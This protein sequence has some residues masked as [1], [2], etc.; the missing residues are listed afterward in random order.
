[1]KKV[2]AFVGSARKKNTYNSVKEFL[3]RLES[4]GGVETEIVC[5]HDYR[6]D[7]C[8]GCKLCMDKGEELCPLKDDRDMLLEK[9]ACSDGVILASP[10][11]AFQVSGM[12]KN[13]LDRIGGFNLHRPRF[14]GKAFTNIVVQGI[15]GGDKIVKYLDFVGNGLGFTTAKGVCLTALEPMS[16]YERGKIEKAIRSFY[17]T[18]HQPT[19]P[20]P[21]ILKLMIFRLSRTSMKITLNEKY[22]DYAYYQEKGWFESDYYYETSLNIFKKMLGRLFDAMAVNMTKKKARAT[23]I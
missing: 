23:G 19:Y 5:L 16:E 17:E 9:I 21:S 18:L 6:I 20:V 11:Y 3:H 15:Y 7:T 4:F 12:M 14:F 2:T 22:R 1:M 13:F 8:T 10:N